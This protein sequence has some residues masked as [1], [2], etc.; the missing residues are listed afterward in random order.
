MR[1]YCFC[2]Y[3]NVEQDEA[4]LP[5]VVESEEISGHLEDDPHPRPCGDKVLVLQDLF[6]AGYHSASQERLDESGLDF[7]HSIMA[8]SRLARFHAVSYAMRKEKGLDMVKE[9]PFLAEDPVYRPDT[10]ELFLKT[11]TSIAT[12]LD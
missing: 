4:K 5:D 12:R 10:A 8:I 6:A 9:Y 7:N 2:R 1:L 3:K 11:Q